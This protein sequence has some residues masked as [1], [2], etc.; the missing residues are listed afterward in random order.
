MIQQARRYVSLLFCGRDLS[1][2]RQTCAKP[3]VIINYSIL[4]AGCLLFLSQTALA[5]FNQQGS[6]L[7]GSGAIGRS[8]QGVSVALSADGN[9]AIIG[10]MLDDNFK[11]AAW[12]FTRSGDTW[13]ERQKLVGSEAIGTA[14]QGASVALS[15]D[16][17]TAIVGGIGDDSG[18]GAAWVF[19]RSGGSWIEQQKLVGSEAV[20]RAAQ[21]ASVALSAD[22]NTAI[23]GG[24]DHD[25]YMG[26]AWVFRH[27]GGTWIEQQRLVGSE[28]IGAAY[29]G[30]AVALS[31]DGNMAIIGGWGDNIYVGAA[32]V[33]RRSGGTWIEQQKLLGSET[34]GPAQQGV[35]VALSADAKTAIV[36]GKGDN[37]RRGAAW[38]FRRSGGTWIEQQKLVGGGAVGPVFSRQGASVALSANGNTAIVG[39]HGDDSYKG[40]TWVFTRSFGTWTQLQKLVGAEAIGP[41]IIQGG[42]VA[43][44]S[45]GNTAIIGGRG[46]NYDKGA[47][48]VYVKD[49]SAVGG[50]DPCLEIIPT[51]FGVQV[52]VL[53]K[54]CASSAFPD[55]IFE[56]RITIQPFDRVCW[57]V[58]GL[59]CPGCQSGLC[60]TFNILFDN[61]RGLN[62]YLVDRT[63]G[64]IVSKG[65]RLKNDRVVVSFKPQLVDM[66]ARKIMPHLAL[67]VVPEVLKKGINPN[68]KPYKRIIKLKLK[69]KPK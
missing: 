10:G 57:V 34:I 3:L 23:I 33:F 54:L 25:S 37:G 66:K 40:A 6:K 45:N 1:V 12:V 24:P 2:P 42:S 31:A 50:R 48:W 30:A 15:A 18:K 28:A 53:D 27:S 44:S 32:W 17:N 49:R 65:N 43:L 7:V 5:Q 60:P 19:K 68:V 20:G 14:K 26:A 35:S 4:L 69:T 8:W 36:G 51:N 63:S 58:R 46:D 62:V 55:V 59:P 13:T 67:V 52:A 16:G 21:G 38:V 47:A 61:V 29:Q 56:N 64:K 22:G 39:G 41:I 11:G 9:T